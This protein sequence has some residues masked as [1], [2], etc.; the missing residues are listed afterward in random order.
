ML[1]CQLQRNSFL[2][3]GYQLYLFHF[4]HSNPL[5]PITAPLLFLPTHHSIALTLTALGHKQPAMLHYQLI[6]Q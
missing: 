5:T 6:S 4:L 3:K 1:G 2:Q